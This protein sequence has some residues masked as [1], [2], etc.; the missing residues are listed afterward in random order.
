MIMCQYP[1]P[2][3]SFLFEEKKSVNQM[4]NLLFAVNQ[5]GV[6]FQTD[7]FEKS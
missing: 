7:V 2:P 4:R 3:F 1:I 5:I 6:D